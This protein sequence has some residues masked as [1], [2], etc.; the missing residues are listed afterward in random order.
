[1]IGKRRAEDPGAKRSEDQV[2]E[3]QSQRGSGGAF[4][5]VGFQKSA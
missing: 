3:Q 5:C 1:V 4:D 2:H